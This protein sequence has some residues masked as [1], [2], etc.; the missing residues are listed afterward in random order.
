MNFFFLGGRRKGGGV[1][2]EVKTLGKALPLL[3]DLRT[4]K[5]TII[6]MQFS[7]FVTPLPGFLDPPLLPDIYFLLMLQSLQ[8]QEHNN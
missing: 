2:K 4:T 1:S 5:K 7:N 3:N 6:I 8:F